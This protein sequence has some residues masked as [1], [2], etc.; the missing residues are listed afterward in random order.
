MA[1][2]IDSG[3]NLYEFNRVNMGKLPVLKTIEEFEG[4][5][6][7]IENFINDKLGTYYMMLNHERK[8]FTL[9]NFLQGVIV[10][11]KTETMIND[12]LECMDNR[13]LDIIDISPDEANMALEIWVKER[14][15]EAV[16]MYLLFPYDFGVIEY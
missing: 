10:D 11:S 12:V 1:Q 16:Y 6:L 5:K 2:E 9:F 14:Q 4:A 8:D 15:T 13:S 7:V 3:M